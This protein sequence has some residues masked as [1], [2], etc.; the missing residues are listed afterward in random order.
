MFRTKLLNRLPALFVAILLAGCSLPGTPG[1]P[2]ATPGSGGG[3][4]ASGPCDNTLYPVAAGATWNYM[5]TGT[6]EGSFDRTILTVD[7]NGF[8]DQDVFDAGTTR[9]GIWSCDSGN[10]TALDPVGGTAATVQTTTFGADFQT[11]E[12]DGVTLPASVAAGNTWSQSVTIEGTVVENS[13]SADASNATTIA[14]TAVGM[15]SVTVPAGTFDAMKVTCQ[16]TINITITMEGAVVPVPA[17]NM[18]TD[19]WYAPGVGLVKSV[20]TGSDIDTTIVLLAYSLP[21]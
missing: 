17:I 10:L 14:C 19:S 13:I 9:T 11:T 8:T 6:T 16:D 7:N 5:M 18:T 3:I 15:E 21:H 2:V 20:S 4:S 12:Q 1:T